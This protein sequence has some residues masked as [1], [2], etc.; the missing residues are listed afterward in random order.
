MAFQEE[1]H[2]KIPLKGASICING[3]LSISRRKPFREVAAP[4]APDAPA[5]MGSE[6]RGMRR[7]TS[8]N[9]ED[10]G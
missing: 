1:A 3:T 6:G 7:F 10:D 5:A 2:T 4:D 9:K 8:A